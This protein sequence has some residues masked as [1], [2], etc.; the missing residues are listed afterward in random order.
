[1]NRLKQSIIVLLFLCPLMVGGCSQGETET[2][3]LADNDESLI[4]EETISPNEDYV[5]SQEDIVYYTIRI[6]QGEDEKVT[7]TADSNALLFEEMDYEVSADN[8][9]SKENI[10]IAWTTMMGN[11]NASKEDQL[12]IAEVKISSDEGV[13]DERKINFASNAFDIITQVAG[14]SDQN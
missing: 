11:P 12:A 3:P 7:V 13:L 10:E 8:S 1:M 4:Y 14:Q 2:D 6:Y 9:I 5:S